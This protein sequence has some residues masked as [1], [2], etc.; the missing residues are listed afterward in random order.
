[1]QTAATDA[2]MALGLAMV[3]GLFV[4]AFRALT[5]SSETGERLAGG[6]LIGARVAA[7]RSRHLS[8][9]TYGYGAAALVVVT[10]I[11][12]LTANNAQVSRTFFDVALIYKFY[13]LVLKAFWTNI[14]I[15]YRRGPCA[16]LGTD[17]GD[18]E[19]RSR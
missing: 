3:A 7:V 5:V 8:F 14:Y 2:I 12:F 4:P 11:A 19:A 16:R 6:D 1:M 15:F 17:R 10:A 9:L 13:P 18:S